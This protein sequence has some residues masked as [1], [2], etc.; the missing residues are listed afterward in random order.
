MQD[1]ELCQ[2]ILWYLGIFAYYL[3]CID[4]HCTCMLILAVDVPSI[5]F[6]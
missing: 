5:D 2:A 4:K 6:D 3:L 1:F